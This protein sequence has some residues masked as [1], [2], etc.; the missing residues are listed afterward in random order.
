MP[1]ATRFSRLAALRVRLLIGGGQSSVDQAALFNSVAVRYVDLLDTY[2]TPGGLCHPADNFGGLLAVAEGAGASVA[3]F[4]LALAVAYDV[5][6]RFSASVPVTDTYLKKH[7]AL[8][9]G[10]APIET[11]LALAREQ[12][13]DNRD[14]ESVDVEVFQTAYDIA[15]GGSFGDK[16]AP[17]TKEQ[18]D[19]N[20]RYLLAAALIDGQ[21]GPEQL[22]TERIRRS[23]VQALLGRVHVRPDPRLTAD[24][25][26][27]TPVRLTVVL[28]DG[29]R[30]SREQKDFEGAPS[31][32]LTWERT[33]Q[34]FH[35]LAEQYADDDLRNEIVR[36]VEQFGAEPISTLTDLLTE[37]STEPQLPKTRRLL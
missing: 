33:V 18:A 22:R 25:P 27:T 32:P 10:Q 29:R 35:W 8:I 23:D 36:A 37:V 6:C 24:Y 16:D 14:V 12:G 28:R 34:K 15:G 31:R 13:I 4:V 3:D 7:R 26:S 30:L 20:L 1:C 5:Q 9:H 19:Y 2:L 11:I 21:V 17:R